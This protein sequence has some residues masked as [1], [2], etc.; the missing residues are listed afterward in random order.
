MS[1]KKN[2]EEI[3]AKDSPS[4][5]QTLIR[6]KRVR[7]QNKIKTKNQKLNHVGNKIEGDF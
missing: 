1:R 4:E 5:W 2:V 3:K 7:K 6:T